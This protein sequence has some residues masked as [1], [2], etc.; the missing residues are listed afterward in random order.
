MF[1]LPFENHTCTEK[2]S[3]PGINTPPKVKKF[4]YHARFSANPFFYDSLFTLRECA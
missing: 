2:I 4:S 3:L 1:F